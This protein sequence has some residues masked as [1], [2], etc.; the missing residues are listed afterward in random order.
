MLKILL[1]EDDTDL[2]QIVIK[3]LT[4]KNYEVRPALNG[5]E[6]LDLFYEEHFDLVISDIMMPQMDGYELATQI[7]QVDG[8]VPIIFIT[9]RN[10][11]DS[12]AKGYNSGID[13]YIVK[14]VDLRELE[15]HISAILRR[16]NIA[17]SKVLTVGNLELDDARVE[18]KIDGDVV[19][20]TLREFQILFKL[21]SYPG[22]V[23]TRSQL[24]E[25]FCGFESE[26]TLRTIDVHITNIRNKTK[27][28]D[29]F[30]IKTVRGLGY[31]AVIL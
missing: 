17:S 10:D 30:N 28:C 3:H 11:F 13:D 25:E 4:M 22:Q 12:K 14:P 2:N 27:N 1:V 29:G 23:F 20:M 7:R 19:E 15:L 5:E 31:K 21:L 16:A 6:A 8:D 24:M 9:A 18:A 26:S